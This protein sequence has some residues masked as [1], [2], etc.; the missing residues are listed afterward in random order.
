MPEDD[1]SLER[2]PRSQADRGIDLVIALPTGLVS[3]GFTARI[4]DYI[5]T[6]PPEWGAAISGLGFVAVSFAGIAA[7]HWNLARGSTISGGERLDP[8]AQTEK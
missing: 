8:P 1:S 4:I 2:V 3:V 7:H 5:Q 6:K